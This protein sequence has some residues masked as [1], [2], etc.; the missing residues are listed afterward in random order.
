MKE[1]ELLIILKQLYKFD[2]SSD[3]NIP[4]QDL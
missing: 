3:S 4:A 1:E 2:Q